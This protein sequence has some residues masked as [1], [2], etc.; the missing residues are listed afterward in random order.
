M[1]TI[2]IPKEAIH[3]FLLENN[4]IEEAKTF[5]YST[6]IDKFY[7][8]SLHIKKNGYQTFESSTEKHAKMLMDIIYEVLECDPKKI[9]YSRKRNEE[10]LIKRLGCYI[11]WKYSFVPLKVIGKMLGYADHSSVWYH[12]DG[13]AITVSN[14]PEFNEALAKVELYVSSRYPVI[15]L[16]PKESNLPANIYK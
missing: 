9:D 10:V 6:R 1:I 3:K 12:R 2:T 5:E 8:F 15:R 11:L 13:A 7:E 4:L 14:S 16:L